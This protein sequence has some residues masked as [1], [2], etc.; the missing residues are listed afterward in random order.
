MEYY[1]AQYT[2]MATGLGGGTY[3]VTVSAVNSCQATATV[4]ITEPSKLSHTVSIIQPGC[5]VSTG[6]AT[7]SE[8]GGTSPYTYAW[9]PSGG[10]NATATGLLREIIQ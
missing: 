3:T 7:V 10:N 6:T 8:S 9:S 4:I 2:A 5:A 1:P